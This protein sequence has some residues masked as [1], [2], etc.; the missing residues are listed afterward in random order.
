AAGKTLKILQWSHFV[1]DYDKWFDRFA[2]NWGEANGVQVTVD[3]INIGDLV[4]T[5]TSEMSANSGHDLIELRP[6][7]AQFMPNVLAMV[8]F[9][10]QAAMQIREDVGMVPRFSYDPVRKY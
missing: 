4:T 6:E 5:T 10:Q 2:Q 8:V 9:N 3:H 1:P 7:A